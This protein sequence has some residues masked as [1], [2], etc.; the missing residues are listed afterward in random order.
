MNCARNSP[1]LETLVLL[2]RQPL[3]SPQCCILMMGSPGCDAHS[4]LYVNQ[5]HHADTRTV[6]SGE[7]VKPPRSLLG[8]PELN[9]PGVYLPLCDRLAID[10]NPWTVRV[11][12]ASTQPPPPCRTLEQVPGKLSHNQDASSG[13]EGQVEERCLEQV[14]SMV[15]G[16]V[17]KD[18]DTACKLLNIESGREASDVDVFM[19]RY[20]PVR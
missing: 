5:P 16:E 17:L 7:D 8:L 10:E 12:D 14:Q 18:V 9:W 2:K 15:V 20:V 3:T 13:M 6:W 11:N 19:C 4:P 1:V